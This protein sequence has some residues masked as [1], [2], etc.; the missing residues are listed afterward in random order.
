MNPIQVII[1]REL[2]SLF[3]TSVAYVFI[4]IFL[5]MAGVCTFVFGNLYENDHADL[6]VFFSFHPWL[7][8][9]F[10]PAIAMRSWAEERRNG[11]IE[12]LLTLPLTTNSIVIGKFIALWIVLL[13]CLILTLPIW[14][15]VNYLGAP[16]N[17]IILAA[18]FGSW[19]MSGA[20]LS[21]S[22]C[23]SALTKNQIVALISSIFCCF[24][25]VLIG[26]PLLQNLLSTSAPVWLLDT[27]S[28]FSFLAHYQDLA[29]GLISLNSLIFYVVTIVVFL[30][31]SRMIID[32]KKAS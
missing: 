26:S 27:V 23:F 8:L 15:T 12:L 16:D 10:V 13:V 3:S 30:V 7:Y 29:R 32:M 2:S 24:L 6:S 25:F 1:N 28:N 21:V 9:F 22:M 11:T 17:G 4:F 18:Y 20:F 5:V 19:L 31:A 14:L